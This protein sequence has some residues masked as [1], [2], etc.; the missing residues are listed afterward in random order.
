MLARLVHEN[1]L[2]APTHA[3]GVGSEGG[4]DA[5]G[6][7]TLQAVQVLQHAA[8]GPIEVRAVLEDH[9]D[10]GEPEKGVAANGLDLRSRDES[11]DNR[12]GDLVLDQVGV[13]PLPVRVDDD[14]HI[15]EVR[16]SV[17]RDAPE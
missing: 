15:R 17:E 4:V 7:L 1:V 14:L 10:V 5:S 6:K 12:I 13:L 3:G 8:P 11:G 2:E 16:K 9:I